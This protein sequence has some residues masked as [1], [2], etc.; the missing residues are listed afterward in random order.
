VLGR[1]ADERLAVRQAK[2]QPILAQMQ[3]WLAARLAE[4]SGRSKIAEAIRHM[5]SHWDGL[6]IFLAG[7]RVEVDNNTVE[8]PIRHI[9][10][11]K[12]NS[13]FAGSDDGADH[14]AIFSS[15]INTA[16]LC[17]IDPQTYLTDVLE[18]IVSGRTK[19]SQLHELLPWVWK[20]ARPVDRHP[21]IAA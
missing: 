6:T 18:R 14:W 16:K 15:L 12:K 7:G 2:T 3:S 13:L 20:A 9:A 1:P 17:D 5:L 19:M 10:L 8:R 4:V 11:D 21:S